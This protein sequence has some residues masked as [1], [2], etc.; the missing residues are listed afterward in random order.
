MSSISTA[1]SAMYFG[2]PGRHALHDP[3]A[4]GLHHFICV[5]TPHQSWAL[6]TLAHHLFSRSV[7]NVTQLPDFPLA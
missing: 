4:P 6:T 2:W 1:T 7:P 5:C 3:Y